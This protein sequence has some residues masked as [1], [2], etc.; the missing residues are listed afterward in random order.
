MSPAGL[1]SFCDA[2]CV[3]CGVV[4]AVCGVVCGGVCGVVCGVVCGGAAVAFG[5]SVV[6]VRTAVSSSFDTIVVFVVAVAALVAAS[7]VA[8]AGMATAA[9]AAV[10]ASVGDDG[11]DEEL[12]EARPTAQSPTMRAP[13]GSRGTR[14]G[15]RR[16]AE[17]RRG[18]WCVHI[19]SRSSFEGGIRSQMM[20]LD[21]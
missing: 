14:G 2:F 4:R 8:V 11:V 10:V 12:H 1:T 15:R 18:C 21:P 6:S 9:V 16:V 3:V 20:R 7:V 19:R 17:R 5:G 13:A